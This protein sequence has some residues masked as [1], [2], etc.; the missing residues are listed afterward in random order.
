MIAVFSCFQEAIEADPHKRGVQL[1]LVRPPRTK[2][3]R[4]LWVWGRNRMQVLAAVSDLAGFTAHVYK[5]G[6]V[7]EANYDGVSEMPSDVAGADGCSSAGTGEESDALPKREVTYY[8]VQDRD[9]VASSDT[10]GPNG[11][12]LE[13]AGGAVD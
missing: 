8:R 11:G 3:Y 12:N 6:I 2:D 4:E 1:Y 5:P 13:V 10:G 7:L 9:P